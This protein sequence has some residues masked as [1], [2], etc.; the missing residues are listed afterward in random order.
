[1]LNRRPEPEDGGQE[2][3]EDDDRPVE[4]DRASTD[5]GRSEGVV[6]AIEAD[7]GPASE[8]VNGA[9]RAASPA[10]TIPPPSGW[11]RRRLRRPPSGRRHDARLDAG[12]GARRTLPGSCSPGATGARARD[13]G[14]GVAGPSHGHRLARPLVRMTRP[15]S[16]SARRSTSCHSRPSCCSADARQTP[17]EPHRCGEMEGSCARIYS[18]GP[19]PC[20]LN[21]R[22]ST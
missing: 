4:V 20:S 10:V 7:G 3:Q 19:A 15:A 5:G 8:K 2:E 6:A 21:R 13:P 11:T 9:R 1:M 17:I 22:G 16:R 14:H 12:R 18:C